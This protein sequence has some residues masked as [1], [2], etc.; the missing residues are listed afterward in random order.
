M[1]KQNKTKL[2]FILGSALLLTMAVTSCNNS[3]DAKEE[4]KDTTVNFTPPVIKKDSTDTM[5]KTVGNKAPGNENKPV[6]PTP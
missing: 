3:G 1:I 4:K 2:R 6:A 5:E